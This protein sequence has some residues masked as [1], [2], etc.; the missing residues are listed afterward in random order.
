MQKVPKDRRQR[1]AVRHTCEGYLMSI[2]DSTPEGDA[3][4]RSSMYRM[5]RER[6]RL[7]RAV[8]KLIAC[9]V[10][11]VVALARLIGLL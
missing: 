9:L 10:A 7:Y 2:D 3:S 8:V 5:K 1:T 11:T 4:N 6:Y